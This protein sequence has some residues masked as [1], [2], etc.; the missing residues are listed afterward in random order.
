MDHDCLLQ[1]L[2]ANPNHCP[3]CGQMDSNPPIKLFFGQSSNSS[4]SQTS[5]TPEGNPFEPHFVANLQRAVEEYA[6]V[7][8]NLQNIV[9]KEQNARAQVEYMLNEAKR[10]LEH[11]NKLLWAMHH[12]RVADAS[13][14]QAKLESALKEHREVRARLEQTIQ[15]LQ[16]QIRQLNEASSQREQ[17]LHSKIYWL[18]QE[19]TRL[20]QVLHLP[21]PTSFPGMDDAIPG[22]TPETQLWMQPSTSATTNYQTVPG[23]S[24]TPSIEYFVTTPPMTTPVDAQL[25]T[26]PHPNFG[27][28]EVGPVQNTEVP[29]SYDFSNML[30]WNVS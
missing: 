13:V 6:K 12:R 4:T 27:N 18:Q 14:A 25:Q 29:T 26:L 2:S 7:I 22:T 21:A 17:D 5:T 15:M 9:S 24:Y 10:R 3:M 23:H 19:C 8:N 11:Q 16:I 30:G 1:C 20:E 28:Q